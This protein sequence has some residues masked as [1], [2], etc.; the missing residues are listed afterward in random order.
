MPSDPASSVPKALV[1]SPSPPASS[2]M[3]P[4]H[5]VEEA[6]HCPTSDAESGRKRH[7]RMA[8]SASVQALDGSDTMPEM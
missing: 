2:V 7:G 5:D 1:M 6:E 4:V 8:A 3:L